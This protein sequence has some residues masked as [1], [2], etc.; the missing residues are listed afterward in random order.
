MATSYKVESPHH[1]NLARGI[2][3]AMNV[4]ARNIRSGN[5]W[6]PPSTGSYGHAAPTWIPI[7]LPNGDLA[8]GIPT[9]NN[10]TWRVYDPENGYA[11]PQ[12]DEGIARGKYHFPKFDS[13][14]AGSTPPIMNEHVHPIVKTP[15]SYVAVEFEE[16][17]WQ[18]PEGQSPLLKFFTGLDVADYPNNGLGPAI[19][20]AYNLKKS[21]TDYIGTIEGKAAVSHLL[22]IGG[23]P[24]I[25]DYVVS[26]GLPKGA[27][28][29][30]GHL[31]G[32]VA[33]HAAEDAYDL[34]V[35]D[36]KHYGIKPSDR[37]NAGILEELTHIYLGHLNDARSPNDKEMEAKLVQAGF[38][39]WQ[40]A[41]AATGNP[42]DPRYIK[43]MEKHRGLKEFRIEDAST[44]PIRYKDL[45]SNDKASLRKKF[46]EEA[47]RKGLQKGAAEEYA[48]G[49]MAQLESEDRK[50]PSELDALVDREARNAGRESPQPEPGESPQGAE[51]GAD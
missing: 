5:S 12:I 21:L 3:K 50:S 46:A 8:Y 33:V 34:I 45:Y 17:P 42:R 29:G 6:T 26:G 23:K 36:A 16:K 31:N 44:V 4:P 48:D 49:R 25:I 28:F 37:K 1:L 2:P 39:A 14:K 20:R 22:S 19:S 24:E 43:L 35:G 9:S 15:Q 30:V 10:P 11:S 47:K 41:D 32:K 38:H 18:A 40:E 7:H 27:I 51:A 13:W